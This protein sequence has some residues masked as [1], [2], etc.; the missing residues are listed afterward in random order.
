MVSEAFLVTCLAG[1]QRRVK[2]ESESV[3]GEKNWV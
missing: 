2:K 3:G 1:I